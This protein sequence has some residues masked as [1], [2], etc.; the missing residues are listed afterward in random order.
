MKDHNSFLYKNIILSLL[1][2][3]SEIGH[4]WDKDEE[5]RQR[6]TEDCNIDLFLTYIVI[7]YSGPYVL[8]SLTVGSQLG[9]ARGHLN[10]VFSG[11]LV[12][13]WAFWLPESFLPDQPTMTDC[14]VCGHSCIYNFIILSITSCRLFFKSAYTH[15]LLVFLW[16]LRFHWCILCW[17]P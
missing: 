11:L 2:K 14:S 17:N 7:P 3:R 13:F 4:K 5:L 10:A 9:S 1:L 6:L 16:S 15:I 12:A 8:A